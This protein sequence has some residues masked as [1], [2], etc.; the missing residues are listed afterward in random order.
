MCHSLASQEETNIGDIYNIR[1]ILTNSV[2]TLLINRFGISVPLTFLGAYL[3]FKKKVLINVCLGFKKI[4]PKSTLHVKE[5]ERKTDHH[6]E[7]VSVDLC[8]HPGP[9]CS[10]AD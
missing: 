5:K 7:L 9:G 1:H 10:K 2:S 4:D 8:Y 6:S 3:G